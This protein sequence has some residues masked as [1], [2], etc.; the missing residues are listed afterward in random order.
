MIYLGLR[1]KEGVS[2]LDFRAMTGADFSS[3]ARLPALQA[4]V[5]KGMMEHAP[6]FWRLTGAG[7]L[8][9]DAVARELM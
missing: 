2:E 1:T 5:R 4:Y 9:A 8:F 3:S 6:P 7:M